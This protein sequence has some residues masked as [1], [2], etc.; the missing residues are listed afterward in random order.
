MR[1]QSFLLACGLLL[2]AASTFGGCDPVALESLRY[3]I[4]GNIRNTTGQGVAGAHISFGDAEATT[5]ADGSYSVEVL[6][7]ERALSITA[8]GYTEHLELITI[9]EDR[10]VD[11]EL[12]GPNQVSGEVV[13]SQNGQGIGGAVLSFSRSGH[14][15]L[16]ETTGASGSFNIVDAPNGVFDLVISR[17]GFID[18]TQA[19]VNISG[20]S[21]VLDPIALAEEVPVGAVRVVVTWGATPTD[22]DAHLTGPD[23]GGRFHVYYANRVTADASLDHDD[24]S[25]NGPETI[26][27]T[28]P[29]N[30]MYRYSIHNFSDQSASGGQGIA[31]SPTRVQVYDDSG[32]IRSYLAPAATSG[33]TWRVFEMT[34]SG[35]SKTFSDN[36]GAGLGYFTASGSSDTGVFLT[37][38]EDGP[39]SLKVPEL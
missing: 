3:T 30:G 4:T 12:H 22:L 21:F 32:L 20:G 6:G 11:R 27:I 31:A 8:M 19:S 1:L 2:V 29:R 15:E 5:A 24:T 18:Y 39:V 33:N 34:V 17:Q 16:V 14:V 37:G 38:G 35:V 7:G 10:T 36:G 28:I 9:T 13:N 25:S 26:T 23:G